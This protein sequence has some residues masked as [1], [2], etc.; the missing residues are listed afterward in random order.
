MKS[1]IVIPVSSLFNDFNYI[2]TVPN[3]PQNYRN[4]LRGVIKDFLVPILLKPSMFD[5]IYNITIC[6]IRTE[7]INIK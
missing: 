4:F 2:I 5:R 1:C 6:I 3:S 7:A